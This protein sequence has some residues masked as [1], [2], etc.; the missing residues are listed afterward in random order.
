MDGDAAHIDGRLREVRDAIKTEKKE[1][2]MRD[3]M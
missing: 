1:N 3:A 2:E